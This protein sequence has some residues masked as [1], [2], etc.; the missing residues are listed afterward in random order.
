MVGISSCFSTPCTEVAENK[1]TPEIPPGFENPYL[2][3]I[4]EKGK[5]KINEGVVTETQLLDEGNKGDHTIG[6]V[7]SSQ[8]DNDLFDHASQHLRFSS[9][10]SM[11]LFN[12][13]NQSSIGKLTPFLNEDRLI[14]Y[15][16]LA[17]L[18]PNE[19]SSSK[20]CKRRFT[21]KKACSEPSKKCK[22]H[23]GDLNPIP[24]TETTYEAEAGETQPRQ[25][26]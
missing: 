2:N 20:S 11:N 15:E 13:S 23:S 19:A 25:S 14:P 22:K 8:H 7:T 4:K 5:A 6:V 9:S 18:V 3:L 17:Q 24:D 16:H 21:A 12:F 10:A 1:L 26:P